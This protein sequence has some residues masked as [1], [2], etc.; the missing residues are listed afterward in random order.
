M[1]AS[2]ATQPYQVPGYLG[3][4]ASRGSKAESGVPPPHPQAAAS[5]QTGGEADKK[6]EVCVC[7]D[8]KMGILTRYL[9]SRSREQ[10]SATGEWRVNG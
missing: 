10:L 8:G 5:R 2:Y 9:G 3:M 6:R 7:K 4:K 1:K